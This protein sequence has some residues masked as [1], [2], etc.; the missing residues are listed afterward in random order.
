[1]NKFGEFQL[2]KRSA[3]SQGILEDPTDLGAVSLYLRD[4]GN[5][6]YL[7]HEEELA[8]FA[9]LDKAWPG[10]LDTP[11]TEIPDRA[12]PIR[13]CIAISIMKL[14]VAI[15]KKTKPVGNIEFSDLIQEG[16]EGALKAINRFDPARGYRLTTYATWW[17]RQAIGRAVSAQSRTI[18]IPV[19]MDDIIKKIKMFDA[20]YLAVNGSPPSIEEI[21]KAINQKPEKVEICIKSD[22]Y[23]QSLDK[24]LNEDEKGGTIYDLIDNGSVSL[25]QLIDDQELSRVMEDIFRKAFTARESKILE[26]RYGLSGGRRHTLEEVGQKFGITRERVRQI[27]AACLRKLRHP[28]RSR[29][30]RKFL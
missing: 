6:H 16:N 10:R 8:L 21:A 29:A 19:H 25:D 11:P 9:R 4:I 26:L 13:S 30:L 14:V 12:K 27:E 23:T 7:F 2:T 20:Q 18:R 1:M 28:C 17:I 5:H 24:M 15:A 3:I 22:Q